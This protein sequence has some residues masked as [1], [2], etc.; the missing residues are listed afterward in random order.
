MSAFSASA[1]VRRALDPRRVFRLGITGGIASGKSTTRKILGPKTEHGGGAHPSWTVKIVDADQLGRDC[2]V[3]GHPCLAEVTA[4]FGADRII[5]QNTGEV[6]RRAL[7]SIVFS[8]AAEM[9]RLNSIVWPHI[10][11][12]LLQELESVEAEC[13]SKNSSDSSEDYFV[14]VVEAA[15]MVK[16]GWQ[17]LFDEV[18]VVYTD[19]E[20]A[21]QRLMARN[22]LSEVDARKRQR[23]QM[24]NEERFSVASRK[25]CNNGN[26]NDLEILVA[27]EWRLLQKRLVQLGRLWCEV[28]ES[29]EEVLW[30]VDAEDNVI[31]AERRSKLKASKLTY[32]ATFIFVRKAGSEN[33]YVQQRS[34][35]KDWCPGYLDPVTGG[36]LAVGET[37]LNS[38]MRELQEELG[39]VCPSLRRLFSVFYDGGGCSS[40]VWGLAVEC[41]VGTSI[42]DLK[43]QAEEVD[44]VHLMHPLELLALHQGEDPTTPAHQRVCPDS[45]VALRKYIDTRP[46]VLAQLNHSKHA[47]K[48]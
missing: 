38:A 40:P 31:G 3:K 9:E 5:D 12:M 4:A 26:S 42:D 22:G 33:L 21:I 28:K 11:S 44:A 7:G 24:T 18:W 17:D 47:S 36:C 15:V 46:A 41:E 37:Y 14:I 30:V 34:M 25:L 6:D 27:N 2:Y 43:I 1:A 39:I 16:A 13:A 23:A 8:D 45:V 35:S 10:R 29:G 20:I 19:P 32:R 48:V